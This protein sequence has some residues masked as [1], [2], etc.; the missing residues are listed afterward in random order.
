MDKQALINIFAQK[1]SRRDTT[2]NAYA[3]RLLALKRGYETYRKKKS[4]R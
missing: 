1:E 2:N 3:N 4:T